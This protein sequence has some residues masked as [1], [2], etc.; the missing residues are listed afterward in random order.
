[1][2]MARQGPALQVS[3][4]SLQLSQKSASASSEEAAAGAS[5]T[6]RRTDWGAPL[7]LALAVVVAED[8]AASERARAR[9]RRRMAPPRGTG[10]SGGGVV[11]RAVGRGVPER[12][13]LQDTGTPLIETLAQSHRPQ[14]GNLGGLPLYVGPA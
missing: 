3:T 2:G 4:D 8:T 11:E 9:G 10:N 1:M 13:V 14:H 7:Q 6:A 12:R 5:V